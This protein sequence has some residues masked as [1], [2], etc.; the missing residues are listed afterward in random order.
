ML[1]GVRAHTL[2]SSYYVHPWDPPVEYSC[3]IYSQW[4]TEWNIWH[5]KKFSSNI[6][7]RIENIRFW[8]MYAHKKFS[9]QIVKIQHQLLRVHSSSVSPSTSFQVLFAQGAQERIRRILIGDASCVTVQVR[10]KILHIALQRLF[11]WILRSHATPG[12]VVRYIS[13]ALSLDYQVG[14]SNRYSWKPNFLT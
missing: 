6:F 3:C 4:N 11:S 5:E 2:I 14:R 7:A 1:L 8:Y 12:F 13:F 10:R 9:K